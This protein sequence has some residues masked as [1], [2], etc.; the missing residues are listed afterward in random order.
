MTASNL[1]SGNFDM[2]ALHSLADRIVAANLTT[3]IYARL[4]T[5]QS[6][7]DYDEAT[8]DEVARSVVRE[9]MHTYSALL[10]V[11]K[12]MHEDQAE[13]GNGP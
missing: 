5:I 4:H 8:F 13:S 2:A 3:A 11:F 7:E 9:V 6:R 1:P 10:S 12:G